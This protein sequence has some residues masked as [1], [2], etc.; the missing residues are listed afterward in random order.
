MLAL[1]IQLALS[2]HFG[3]GA[4]FLLA[5]ND[6]LPWFF[7]APGVLWLAGRFPL[8]AKHR[9]RNS[10]LHLAAGLLCSGLLPLTSFGLLRLAGLEPMPGRMPPRW[11]P[12]REERS[13]DP[14]L[15]GELRP[16]QPPPPWRMA[17]GRAPF[18]WPVYALI[19]TAAHGWR[20]TGRAHERERRATELERLLTEARL[21]SL[22]HQLHPHFLFNTLNT[23]AEFIHSDPGRAEEMLISLSELL[24]HA[25]RASG[26][27]VV[28]LAEELALLD[29]YLGIQR[30][31][32]GPRLQIVRTIAP[33][34]CPVA[35]PVLMLQ[36]LVENA[37]R[38]GL[39]RSS[40]PVTVTVEASVSAG[41][42]TLAV[43]DNAD[44]GTPAATGEGI[45]L[46]N[47]RQR[48]AALYGDAY[49]FVA[50]PG[51]DGGFAAEISFPVQPLEPARPLPS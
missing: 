41:R 21:T 31:R 24:R 18:H 7:A 20:A 32:F 33:E 14:P 36:P 15:R 8:D 47:T 39:D 3:W 5:A 1:A 9:L 22:T 34:A 6:A 25:L 51:P 23:I 30:A 48:L 42:I 16:P 40:A 27:H 29:L 17:M 50:G 19:L 46:V 45:G 44:P 28:P 2:G 49:R 10:G 26:H 12:P 4:A 37:L 38:H 11:S 35:V 43:R 13:P